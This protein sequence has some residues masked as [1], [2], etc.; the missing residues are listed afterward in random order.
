MSEESY[1][2]RVSLESMTQGSSHIFLVDQ[3]IQKTKI[4]KEILK[5]NTP[6]VW[7]VLTF[8][9]IRTLKSTG[10]DM[11]SVEVHHLDESEISSAKSAA[12]SGI[13]ESLVLPIYDSRVVDLTTSTTNLSD[14][15][16]GPFGYTTFKWKTQPKNILVFLNRVADKFYFHNLSAVEDESYLKEV[17][18][19]LGANLKSR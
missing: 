16:G 10:N 1:V 19:I 8:K 5:N 17:Q 11:T 12:E 4:E 14:I 6:L 3:K 2:K 15:R 7:E 18:N 9:I 13:G